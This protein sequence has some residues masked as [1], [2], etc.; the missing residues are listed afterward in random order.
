VQRPLVIAHRGATSAGPENSLAALAAAAATGAD[1]VETDV[2]ATRDDELFL[3]H[4]EQLNGVS[5]DR[6]TGAE[7]RR[8]RLAGGE[9]IPSLAEGLRALDPRLEVFIEAKALPQSLDGA[10]LDILS[11]GPA[12]GRYRVH[13]FDH[14]I[15]RRLCGLRP[16]MPFGVLQVSYPVEPLGALRNASARALWQ[17]WRL[18]DQELVDMVHRAGARIFAWTVNEPDDLARLAALGVDGLCTDEPVVAR[19]VVDSTLREG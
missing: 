1:G 2:R 3:W 17:E 16:D 4:D 6:L 9:G 18:I 13:A 15:I 11:R 5:F 12:P 8:S 14:R 10:F 19:R 7:V